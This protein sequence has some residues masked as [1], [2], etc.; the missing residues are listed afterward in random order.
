MNEEKETK[1]KILRRSEEMFRQFGFSK[2]TMEEIASDLRI[3]KRTLY[4]HFSN[5][6]NILKE[7]V[8]A[9]KC[10]VDDFIENLVNDSSLTFIE[11]LKRFL[12]FIANQSQKLE[13]PMIHD[14]MKCQPEIWKDIE[15]FRSNRAYKHLS[16]LIEQGKS[17]GV[18]RDDIN[19]EVLVIAYTAA[20]HSIINPATLSKLPVSANQAH[21]DIVKILFEGIFTSEG[22]KK[23]KS[24]LKEYYEEVHV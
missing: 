3:S 5:K 20:I 21:R 15:E 12:N 16:T 4:K 6:E 2:V 8:H 14:L 11:K 18:F 9:N 7:I 19:V 23:Y 22:R 17:D 24:S 10:E 1:L 13:G